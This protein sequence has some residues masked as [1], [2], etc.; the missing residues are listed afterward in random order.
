MARGGRGRGGRDREIN[1]N[2]GRHKAS[3]SDRQ[4]DKETDKETNKQTNSQI[5]RWTYSL[6]CVS[7]ADKFNERGNGYF[8]YKEKQ[9]PN[10][11]VTSNIGQDLR[12]EVIGI[13]L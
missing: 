6:V 8:A 13:K 9:S 2:T 10:G 5:N 4:S 12:R 3:Q 11:I 7:N 1:G